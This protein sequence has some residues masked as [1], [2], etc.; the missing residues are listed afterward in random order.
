MTTFLRAFRDA[1]VLPFNRRHGFREM[2][3]GAMAFAIVASVVG[4][5]G[6]T[7]AQKQ[8]SG[9]TSVVVEVPQPRAD[10]HPVTALPELPA[11]RPVAQT[12][13]RSQVTFQDP[14]W[15]P[16]ELRPNEIPKMIVA[17]KDWWSGTFQVNGAA[18]AKSFAA[19]FDETKIEQLGLPRRQDDG[20]GPDRRGAGAPGTPAERKWG[21][22]ARDPAAAEQPA[23]AVPGQGRH[24]G[25]R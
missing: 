9:D 20:D 18:L 24:G 8:K 19:A 14:N 2:F 16:N 17:E 7:R 10:T 4:S 23:H 13:G 5:S 15:L 21:M 1:P 3:I 22:E 25:R 12:S 11:A 6:C